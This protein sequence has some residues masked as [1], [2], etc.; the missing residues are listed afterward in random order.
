MW[1]YRNRMSRLGFLNNH[2]TPGSGR[3]KNETMKIELDLQPVP[4]ELPKCEVIAWNGSEWLVGYFG[5]DHLGRVFVEN[6]Y[7]ALFN[8]KRF[9]P[10][11]T[12][13]EDGNEIL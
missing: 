9:A 2:P 4:K 12:I 10:L 7:E 6:E 8:I 11:P 1:L 3:A 5:E 13:Y